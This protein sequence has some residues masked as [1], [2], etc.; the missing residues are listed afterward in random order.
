MAP[1][2]K[3]NVRLGRPFPTILL[4]FGNSRKRNTSTF[5]RR[6]EFSRTSARPSFDS[7]DS[8]LPP[9]VRS[10]LRR[11]QPNNV[12]PFSAQDHLGAFV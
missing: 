9:A 8:G 6:I 2:E 11:N 3:S 1:R 5:Q 7:C 12:P 10:K 4:S